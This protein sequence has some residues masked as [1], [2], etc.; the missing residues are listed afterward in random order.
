MLYRRPIT[1]SFSDFHNVLYVQEN[2]Q[3]RS[4]FRLSFVSNTSSFVGGS[5]LAISCYFSTIGASLYVPG[6]RSNLSLTINTFVV[7][8]ILKRSSCSFSLLVSFPMNS[9]FLCHDESRYP[10]S[11]QNGVLGAPGQSTQECNSSLC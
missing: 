4:L 5:F 1:R 9:I 7:I 3:Q 2:V 6:P 10:Q 8:D 11:G